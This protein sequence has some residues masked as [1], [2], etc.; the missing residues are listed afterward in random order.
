MYRFVKHRKEMKGHIE[1]QRQRKP[2]EDAGF[3]STGPRSQDID[4]GSE[5]SGQIR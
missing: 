4:E 2:K 3:P 1:V 5:K